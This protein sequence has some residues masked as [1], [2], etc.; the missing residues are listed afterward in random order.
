MMIAPFVYVLFS[1]S[2]ILPSLWQGIRPCF[3]CTSPPWHYRS[4]TPFHGGALLSPIASLL[5]DHPSPSD[6]TLFSFHFLQKKSRPFPLVVLHPQEP[7]LAFPGP[8]RPG[9]SLQNINHLMADPYPF[10]PF[11]TAPP[12]RLPSPL[13]W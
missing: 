12:A 3:T 11:P 1:F 5:N 4:E 8:V 7:H 13:V 6:R 9:G 2:T 10:V